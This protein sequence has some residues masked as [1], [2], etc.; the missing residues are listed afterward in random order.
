MNKLFYLIIIAFLLLQFTACNNDEPKV[1]DLVVTYETTNVSVLGG[2]DGSI[3]LTVSGGEEPFTFQWATGESTQ[4]L[5]ELVAGLYEVTITDASEQIISESI[6]ITEPDMSLKTVDL[7][8]GAGYSQDIYYSLK[9]AII[10]TVDR[11]EWDIAFYTNPMSS[12]ILTNDGNGI[13]LF[14]WPAGDKNN[15]ETVDTVGMNLLTAMYNTYSDTS[16]QNGAFDKNNLGH[17]DYGW[18]QYDMTSHSVFGDSIHIIV[19]ADGSAKK[20]FIEKR[21]SST[22]TFYIKFA[23][24]NGENEQQASIEAGSHLDKNLIHFSITNNSVVVHEP[25]S[26]DWDLMFTKYYDESIPYIVTGVLS[27]N[28]VA[29]AEMHD[30]DTSANDYMSGTYSKVINT[31]GS[32]WKDFDMATFA[33]VLTDNLVYFIQDTNGKYHKIVFTAFEGSSSGNITFNQTSYK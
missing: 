29:V 13:K 6:E 31:I 25:A 32:D 1:E 8:V 27:N 2:N 4:N 17:P 3:T 20:L 23:D 12:S 24:I 7:S 26:S 14:V 15:W 33:Y 18:G 21:E 16:W 19:F 5:T 28:N 22:N 10:S 11:T 30:T 9:N